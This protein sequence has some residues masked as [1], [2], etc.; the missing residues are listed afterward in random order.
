MKKRFILGSVMGCLLAALNISLALSF[1]FGQVKIGVFGPL[2]GPVADTGYAML[3]GVEMAADEI[4]SAGGIKGVGKIEISSVDSQCM[5]AKAVDA[6][7]K[8]IYRDKVT[9]AVGDVCSG[10][11]LAAMKIAAQ[12]KVPLLNN[13]STAAAITEQGNQWV[14]RLQARDGNQKLRYS[15]LGY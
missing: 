3:Y 5:P 9:A 10:A 2:T 7:N 1:A 8:L 11:T 13:T 4:N 14:F 15:L 12:E 6:A